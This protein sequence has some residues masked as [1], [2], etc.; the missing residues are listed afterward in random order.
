[1]FG[2]IIWELLMIAVCLGTCIW[3]IGCLGQPQSSIYVPIL[4]ILAIIGFITKMLIP[5]L[6]YQSELDIG[7]YFH[8]YLPCSIMVI[9]AC[10]NPT[11]ISIILMVG[12]CIALREFIWCESFLWS[13]LAQGVIIHFMI[14]YFP[15]FERWDSP[16][17]KRA[18]LLIL[19]KIFKM[20]I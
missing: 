3:K 13:L 17:R 20:Y 1:M 16:A 12:V 7:Y 15:I 4:I 10:T 19:T 14:K 9:I 18:G 5:I 2:A 6:F 8:E 11:I